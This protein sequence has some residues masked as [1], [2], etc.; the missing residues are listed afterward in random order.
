MM[1]RKVGTQIVLFQLVVVAG[2]G[3]G[4]GRGTSR[5]VIIRDGF[6]CGSGQ[7]I[8][9]KI[10]A[11]LDVGRDLEMTIKRGAGGPQGIAAGTAGVCGIPRD[12]V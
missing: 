8:V 11:F 2:C 10:K 4:Q 1:M 12:V 5:E 7:N 9:I 6:I 3:G